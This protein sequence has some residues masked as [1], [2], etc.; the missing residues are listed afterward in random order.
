MLMRAAAC[1]AHHTCS[2]AVIHDQHGAIAVA[3]RAQFR[4]IRN[5]ALHAEYA[6]GDHPQR[7]GEF[8][9]CAQLLQFCSERFG[10]AIFVHATQQT[11]FNTDRQ[12]NAVDNAGVIQ[13]VGH[14][15]VA[16]L[17]QRGEDGLVGVPTTCE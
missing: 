14:H 15:G 13:L 16:W 11:F 10:V 17:A 8:W 2:M 1:C 4:Q 6:V 9:I 12:T 5:T 7:S 3:H